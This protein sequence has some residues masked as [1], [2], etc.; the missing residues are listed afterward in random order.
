MPINYTV[1][2][3]N[4]IMGQGDSRDPA[5]HYYLNKLTSIRFW[6]YGNR[7]P[8]EAMGWC[9]WCQGFFFTAP[10]AHHLV[11]PRNYG[12]RVDSWWNLVPLHEECHKAAHAGGRD[13]LI[14]YLYLLLSVNYLKLPDPDRVAGK[15]A[16]QELV[17]S[18]HLKVHVPLP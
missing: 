15:A 10:S 4:R 6:A 7:L 11:I 5:Q 9:P 13:Q 17:D 3:G 18:L 8:K 14:E 16:L 12:V 1:Y 2:M